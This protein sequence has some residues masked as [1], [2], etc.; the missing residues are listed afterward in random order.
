M[1]KSTSFRLFTNPLCL[2]TYS[3][4]CFTIFLFY[5]NVFRKWNVWLNMFTF[6]LL[7]FRE[8]FLGKWKVFFWI[9]IRKNRMICE[10]IKVYEIKVIEQSTED[11]GQVATTIICNVIN[12]FGEIKPILQ[13]CIQLAH[14]LLDYYFW[15]W[16]CY[17]NHLFLWLKTCPPKYYLFQWFD[18]LFYAI[19][20]INRI[21]DGFDLYFDKFYD[22]PRECEWASS[23]QYEGFCRK[24]NL[25]LCG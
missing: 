4:P 20:M 23:K 3:F 8:F 11:F 21:M 16:N 5:S 19:I 9:E 7:W 6:A 12:E 22:N 24:K 17:F 2:A 25:A 1:D 10:Q 15:R 13:L 18:C 14:M